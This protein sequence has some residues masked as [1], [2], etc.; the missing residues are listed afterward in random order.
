MR[1]RLLDRR[2]RRERASA[3]EV[4]LRGTEKLSETNKRNNTEEGLVKPKNARRSGTEGPDKLCDCCN[5]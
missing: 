5:I 1:S 4:R 3:G 2:K